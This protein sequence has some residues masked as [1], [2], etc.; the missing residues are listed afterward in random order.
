MNNIF[1]GTIQ[2]SGEISS[3]NSILG[4]NTINPIYNND[5]GVVGEINPNNVV[6]YTYSGNLVA[7]GANT[8]TVSQAG[9]SPGWVIIV[10]TANPTNVLITNV[11]G[12]VL[13]ISQNWI[14]QPNIGDIY[15]LSQ[16]TNALILYK[17]SQ[18]KF[19]LGTSSLNYT[20][21]VFPNINPGT[22]VIGNISQAVGEQIIYVGKNGN[23]S[24]SGTNITNSKLTFT[25]AVFAAV[26]QSIN[27]IVCLD[28]GTY[29]ESITIGNVSIFAP[30]ATIT[31][32]TA[33]GVVNIV[34]GTISYFVAFNNCYFEFT[35]LLST[36]INI[37][38]G[39]A[40]I[41]GNMSIGPLICRNGNIYGHINV[42]NTTTAFDVDMGTISVS[43]AMNLS[44]NLSNTNSNGIVYTSSSQ[45]QNTT[46][47]GTGQQFW[48]DAYQVINHITNYNNPH[49]V[50]INQ[51]SPLTTKGDLLAYTNTNTRLPIGTDGTVLT[52]NSAA[53]SGM[54]WSSTGAKFTLCG[55]ITIMPLNYNIATFTWNN[56][57]YTGLTSGSLIFSLSSATGVTITFTDGVT[58]YAQQSSMASGYYSIPVTIPIANTVI[59]LQINGVGV[60]NGC[61]L[62]YI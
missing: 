58:T 53:S 8:V 26:S 2:A 9:I 40:N 14:T 32:I 21:N 36:G 46:T 39:T 44:T 17:S 43:T 31:S 54:A 29:M 4:L 50:T 30:N 41:F 61:I 22:L 51:V 34:I 7:V 37:N 12:F 55:A 19:Y 35:N 13:T 16:D 3:Q 10:P 1:S 47:S 48:T 24:N 28:A 60:L 27:L 59:N 6:T 33:T 62:Q 57:V 38:G 42:I 49:Q 18:N 52:A 5:I 20:N 15:H 25:N 23:D 56:S 11:V 45:I